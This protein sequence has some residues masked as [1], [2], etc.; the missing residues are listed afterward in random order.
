MEQNIYVQNGFE[1][2][3]DYLISLSEEYGVSREVVFVM[4]SVLGE[5]EDFDGLVTSIQDGE[6]GFFD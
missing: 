1:N 6:A 3:K 4:A 2:R 5:S